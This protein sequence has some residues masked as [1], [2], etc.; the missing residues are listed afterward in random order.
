MQ[1]MLLLY[2]TTA[3]MAVVAVFCSGLCVVWSVPSW[4][5]WLS[6]DKTFSMESICSPQE[7]TGWPARIGSGLIS[8]GI[9]TCAIVAWYGAW[10]VLVA[11]IDAS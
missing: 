11:V 8:I 6:K 2:I 3:L 4:R 5:R 9:A 1:S 7:L 10:S